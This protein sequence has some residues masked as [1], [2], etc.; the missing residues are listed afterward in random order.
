MLT[1]KKFF[2][3]GQNASAK[4]DIA[5][6]PLSPA[7]LACM[8]NTHAEGEIMEQLRWIQEGQQLMQKE[9]MQQMRIMQ[10]HMQ[11]EQMQQ[12]RSM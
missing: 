3:G 1:P 7:P 6:P 10:E 2:W 4:P 5:A 9:Q 11:K 8:S 12:M